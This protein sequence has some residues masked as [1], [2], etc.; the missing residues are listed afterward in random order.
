M[1]RSFLAKLTADQK[2]DFILCAVLCLAVWATYFNHF[3]NDFHFDDFHT[4]TD[5]IFIRDIH[6]VPRFFTNQALLSAS[7]SFA[8]YRPVVAASLAIDYWMGHAMKPFW[9]HVSTF[10]WFE[11]QLVLMFFLFRRLMEMVYPNPS[12]TWTAFLATA[13]YGLHPVSAETVN[14]IIQRA[15]LY[16]TLGVV[17]SLLLFIAYPAQRKRLWFMLPAIAAFLSKPPALV[18]PGILLAYVFLFELDADNRKWSAAARI[19]APA[20][21]VTVVAAIAIQWMTP[22]GFIYGGASPWLYRL[23]QPWVAL[24]YFVSF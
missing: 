8:V 24:H 21:A 7:P 13:C 19:V 2:R 17:A 9:F 20:L 10:F 18:Y 23:T 16:N 22:P 12:N 1:N 11:L 5:N 15:D 3:S 6:N 14:Y 4:T